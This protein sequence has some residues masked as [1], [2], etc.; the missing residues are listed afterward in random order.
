MMEAQDSWLRALPDEQLNTTITLADEREASQKMAE[1]SAQLLASVR[2]HD[3]SLYC[4]RLAERLR[5][6]T[7]EAARASIRK[8]EAM[9]E[10]ARRRMTQ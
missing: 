2:Q 10:A 1:V 4:A 8:G 5:S 7:P 9:L 3:A 6:I